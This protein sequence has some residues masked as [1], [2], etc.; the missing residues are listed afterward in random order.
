[1]QDNPDANIPLADKR[2]AFDKYRAKWDV[3][4]PIKKWERAVDSSYLNPHVSGPGVHGFIVGSQE[5]I[6]FL[7]LEPVSR[8]V[9]PKE[10]KVP[11]SDFEPLKLAINPHADVLVVI[12]GKVR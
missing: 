6:E 1:M 5:F 12:E 7:S 10:W 3:F 8:G 4:H 9:P 11:L 2:K